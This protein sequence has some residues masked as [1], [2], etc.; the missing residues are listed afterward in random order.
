MRIY[1]S[2]QSL[3][4]SDVERWGWVV[5]MLKCSILLVLWLAGSVGSR[6]ACF[7]FVQSLCESV[8]E[9]GPKWR[10]TPHGRKILQ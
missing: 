6:F 7:F 5:G 10:I 2:W 3:A 1:D 4:C 9:I 8:Y